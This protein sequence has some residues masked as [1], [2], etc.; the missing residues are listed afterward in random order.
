MACVPRAC[1]PRAQGAEKALS[2]AVPSGLVDTTTGVASKAL[3]A[4]SPVVNQLVQV[5]P[6]ASPLLRVAPDAH[7]ADAPEPLRPRSLCR[8]TNP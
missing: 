8:A 2:S 6:L 1:C 3:T 7:C 4:V 5:R